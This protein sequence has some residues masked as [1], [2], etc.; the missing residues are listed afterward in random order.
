MMA[1]N[2][3]KYDVDGYDVITTALRTILNQYPAINSGDEISFSMLAEDG[4]KAMFPTQGAIIQREIEDVTGHVTQTC[5]YPFI[6]RYRAA[7]LT[8]GRK[9]AVKE[10]LDNLG[11]WL[12]KQPVI[13]GGVEY[14]MNDY[15]VLSGDRK[16]LSITRTSPA[17]LNSINANMVEDWDISITTRYRNE[18][19]R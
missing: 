4:G 13:I 1:D 2:N 12:E 6:V 11:K 10:W 15:P 14:K 19:D 3:L 8:Q 17:Y 9:A 18:F 5:L 7:G 16:I